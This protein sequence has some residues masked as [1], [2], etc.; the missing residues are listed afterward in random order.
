MALSDYALTTVATIEDELGI[1]P[2]SED[3]R[4]QRYIHAVSRWLT[5]PAQ[6]NRTLAYDAAIS[7]K[8]AGFGDPRMIIDRP[9]L[10]G[11]TSI[12]Y[13]G[14]TLDA[15]DYETNDAKAGIIY[16]PDGTTWT[17]PAAAGTISSVSLAGMERKLYTVTY[18]GGWWT[19]QQLEGGAAPFGV[20]DLP[21]EIEDACIQMVSMRYGNRGINRSVQSEKTLSESVTYFDKPV[22]QDVVDVILSYRKSW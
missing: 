18:G 5:A 19:P 12:V 16:F 6:M 3:A 21:P 13:D 8:K 7:E 10:V 20:D 1:T 2:G 15:T 11:I 17:A 22:P 9:P 14:T 4:L